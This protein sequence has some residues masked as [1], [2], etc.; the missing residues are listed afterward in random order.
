MTNISQKNCLE[1]ITD[2]LRKIII[3]PTMTFF[4]ASKTIKNMSTGKI[5]HQLKSTH[6]LSAKET[7]SHRQLVL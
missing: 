5:L 2:E 4:I 7:W 6:K 1:V 3:P